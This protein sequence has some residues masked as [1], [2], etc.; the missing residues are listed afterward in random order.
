MSKKATEGVKLEK[1]PDEKIEYKNK[2][3][4]EDK[5]DEEEEIEVKVEKDN[6]VIGTWSWFLIVFITFVVAVF[7]VYF[8]YDWLTKPRPIYFDNLYGA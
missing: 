6:N 5:K 3:K 7:G 2:K 8:V 1:E 4:E